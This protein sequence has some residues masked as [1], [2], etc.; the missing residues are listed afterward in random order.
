M[1]Q[2]FTNKQIS[3]GIFA[4][5]II[6]YLLPWTV[7]I[8]NSLT[9][10]AYDFAE[11]LSKRPFDDTSYNTVLLMRGQLIL[12]TA[13]VMFNIEPPPLTKSWWGI[14]I[15]GIILL[16]AQLPAP[17]A[18]FDTNDVNRQQQ[19][20]LTIVSF[21]IYLIGLTGFLSPYRN[22][23]WLIIAVMGIASTIYALLNAISMM[24]AYQLPAQIGIG[25]ILFIGGYI[26]L[27]VI[28]LRGL[29]KFGGRYKPKR[30]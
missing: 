30:G 25:A 28:A 26:I 8:G 5:A 14:A 13:L 16:I 10:G 6:A 2:Q 12:L 19:V 27:G 21:I 29:I 18:I 17:N 24:Q 3:W 9:M 22:I 1:T 11:W 7:N 20:Y 4:L 23:S 15:I